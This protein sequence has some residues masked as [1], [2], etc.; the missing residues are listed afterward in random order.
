MKHI[1]IAALFFIS[2]FGHGQET[3]EDMFDDGLVH[4][5]TINPSIDLARLIAGTPNINLELFPNKNLSI[6]AGI[7]LT[8]QYKLNSLNDITG[9]SELFDKNI[10]S[11]SFLHA[12]GKYFFSKKNQYKGYFAIGY[13]RHRINMKEFELQ[14]SSS[15]YKSKQI[16]LLG[17]VQWQGAK[18]ITYD[19]YLGLGFVNKK[20]YAGLLG[21]NTVQT[22]DDFDIGTVLCFKLGYPIK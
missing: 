1:Y 10:K 20:T 14:Y 4:G 6:T 3:I 7:G 9:G 18:N 8:M 5:Y 13:N 2:L 22:D 16:H 11:G 15:Y 12:M 19:Y 21:G 17:G